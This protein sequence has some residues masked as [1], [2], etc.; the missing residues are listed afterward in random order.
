MKAY[1]GESTTIS[2]KLL[3]AKGIDIT[4]SA[5]NGVDKY[6]KYTLV[7]EAAEGEFYIP[8]EME[9][10]ISF[11]SEK[12]GAIAKVKVE[13][14]TGKY[15][16]N[17]EAIPG[18]YEIV[19]IVSE[20]APAYGM[21]MTKVPSVTILTPG[22]DGNY[23]TD[24]SKCN[25][26][27]ALNDDTDKMAGARLVAQFVDT[28]G[29]KVKTYDALAN[30]EF[31]STNNGILYV[32][33]YG[34]LMTNSV[35]KVNVII[36]YIPDAS[37]TNVK[38]VVGVATVD[39]REARS[40]S[41]MGID[42]TSAVVSTTAPYNE[43]DFKL[44]FK[45]TLQDKYAVKV[46][47]IKVECIT[48]KPTGASDVPSVSA[49]AGSNGEYTFTICGGEE[50]LP[51]VNG[52]QATTYSYTF[53]ASYGNLSKQFT[54]RVNKPDGKVQGVEVAITGGTDLKTENDSAKALNVTVYE[55]SNGVR[56]GVIEV[57]PKVDK[58]KATAGKY[59]YTITRDGKDITGK[60]TG[61]SIGI[62]LTTI[63]ATDEFEAGTA[64]GQS[65]DVVKKEA[66]GTYTVTVYYA[67]G[68][69]G[70]T[71]TGFVSKKSASVTVTDTQA[72]MS[73]AGKKSN[74]YSLADGA[75]VE[76]LV[77]ACFAFKLGSN[78][79]DYSKVEYVVDANVPVSGLTAGSVCFVNSVDFY[80]L[81]GKS[82]YVKYT[83]QVNNY[84]EVK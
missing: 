71:A 32:D 55:L 57:A 38:T 69:A 73:Y 41:T 53:K 76:E 6:V 83:V 28:K 29:D 11:D 51:V 8:N 80:V 66:T 42:K 62:D 81:V 54:V 61:S 34:Y 74:S 60:A 43:A 82:T 78:D 65:L 75:S 47:D 77:K 30:F 59:Y 20:K 58:S 48:K 27:I 7:E 25:N 4:S 31:E 44:T 17:Y 15:D 52:K 45:D 9:G 12:V 21:D 72:T 22:D 16:D 2:A 79:V 36:Y 35:G 24:F 13:Y 26:V 49:V 10:V 14:V 40:A 68:E 1:A 84:V 23:S 39:V 18:A 33:Q 5:V 37:N 50:V 46:S 56:N 63:N 3:N 67:N 64:S 70:K 19:P